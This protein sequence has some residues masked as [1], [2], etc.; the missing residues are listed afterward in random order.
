MEPSD[1]Q[2]CVAAEFESV[3][4]KTEDHSELTQPRDQ[5]CSI[6]FAA[7]FVAAT[8]SA[9]SVGQQRLNSRQAAASRVSFDDPLEDAIGMLHPQPL[10]SEQF[11]EPVST[12][13][14]TDSDP[15]NALNNT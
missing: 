9:I 7:N 13:G 12:N 4:A 2:V 14:S 10:A 8:N 5:L 11:I 1:M 15:D 6:T 3:G